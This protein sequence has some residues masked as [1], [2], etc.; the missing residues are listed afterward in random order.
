MRYIDQRNATHGSRPFLRGISVVSMATAMIAMAPSA[1]AQNKTYSDGE[2]NNLG[3]TAPATLTVNSG[4]S[5]TQSGAI[6]GSGGN[7]TKSGDGALTLTGSN[8]YRGTIITA[9]SLRIEGGGTVTNSIGLVMNNTNASLTISGAG[10]SFVNIANATLGSGAIVI[11]NGGSYRNNTGAT[12][13]ANAAGSVGSLTVTGPG[14]SFYTASSVG[15]G[16]FQRY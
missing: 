3:V 12:Q 10:S 14:S 2:N 15:S 16:Q 1:F 13:F 6:T 9:G 7:L 11:D 5:A 4:D 8:V